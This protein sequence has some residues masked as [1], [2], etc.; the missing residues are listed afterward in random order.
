MAQKQ[1]MNMSPYRSGGVIQKCI[2]LGSPSL[3]Q[4]G[5]VNAVFFMQNIRY[6]LQ[7]RSL[8]H[9]SSRKCGKFVYMLLERVILDSHECGSYLSEAP[10]DI[11]A[12]NM[13]LTFT[14]MTPHKHLLLFIVCSRY[15]GLRRLALVMLT[16]V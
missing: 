12:K 3:S 16:V 1:Q 4:S 6:N 7:T 15:L 8:V 2:K 10:V 11:L 14:W 5:D 9:V 13:T